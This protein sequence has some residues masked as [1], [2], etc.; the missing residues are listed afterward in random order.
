MTYM[1]NLKAKE[2]RGLEDGTDQVARLLL[3]NCWP[4]RV[5]VISFRLIL[6]V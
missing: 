3:S 5:L 2:I 4:R 6:A 1:D